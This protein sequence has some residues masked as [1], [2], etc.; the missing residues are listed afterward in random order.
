MPYSLTRE[1]GIQTFRT[2][3]HGTKWSVSFSHTVTLKQTVHTSQSPACEGS[4]QELSDRASESLAYLP[5]DRSKKGATRWVQVY[6][7]RE[8]CTGPVER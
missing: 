3:L 4:G 8:T 7:F 5:S 6:P 2:K 1:Q